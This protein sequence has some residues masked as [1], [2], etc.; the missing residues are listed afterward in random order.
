MIIPLAIQNKN[1]IQTIERLVIP[2]D[3]ATRVRI[4]VARETAR[5]Q[6]EHR[7][8]CKLSQKH[9]KIGGTTYV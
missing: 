7:E 2:I 1:G 4:E 6:L 8:F 9:K 3:T 5:A